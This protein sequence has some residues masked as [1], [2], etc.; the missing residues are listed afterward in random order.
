[1]KLYLERKWKKQTYTIGRLF[2]DGE[3]E[4]WRDI[5]GYE[6]LYQ[7]SDAG[8]VRSCDRLIYDR[9]GVSRSLKGKMISP[10][11]DNSGYERTHLSKDGVC[12]SFCVHHLVALAFIGPR[13]KGMDVDHISEDKKDNRACNLRYLSHYENASRSTKGIF[14]KES[15]SMEHNPRTK[16]VVGYSGDEI[17]EEFPCAKYLTVKYGINYSTLRRYLQMGGILIGKTFY[18]YEVVS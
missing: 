18:K 10:S 11:Y 16:R 2:V 7:I 17:V 9:R 4:V 3:N 6:G 5:P 1:M 15:N 14:R 13:P 12:S 8:R